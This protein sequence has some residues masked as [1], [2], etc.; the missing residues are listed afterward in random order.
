[1]KKRE[2]SDIERGVGIWMLW[3]SRDLIWVI[4]HFGALDGPLLVGFSV[5][6]V[7]GTAFVFG[8]VWMLVTGRLPVPW[9]IDKMVGEAER[10]RQSHE[11]LA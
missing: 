11:G 4:R 5:L 10:R 7:I 8:G 6:L 3:R 9:E 2:G 1:M